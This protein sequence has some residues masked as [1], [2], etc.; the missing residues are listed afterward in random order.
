[1]SS[2]RTEDVLASTQKPVEEE[3]YHLHTLET[4]AA[5]GFL[6]IVL[7]HAAEW[8][9]WLGISHK[10]QSNSN[11]FVLRGKQID[12][13]PTVMPIPWWS[14]GEAI[15][16]VESDKPPDTS[17]LNAYES[18]GVF[19]S[20]LDFH[21]AYTKGRTTPTAVAERLL[22]SID[23][24][25]RGREPPLLAIIK[26]S[27][28]A[29]LQ[30]AADSTQRY[31][32]GKP[33]SPIDGV[34]VAVKDELDALPYETGVGTAFLKLKP[35]ADAHC[36]AKLRAAGAVIIGKTNM[37]E[38]GADVTNCNPSTGT[39]RNPYDV[40]RYTGGSS[41]G[42]GAGVA[43]GFCPLAVGADGGGSIRIPAAYNGV[44]GLKPTHGRVSGYG[45]FPLGPSVGVYGPIGATAYDLA[46]GY[47]IMAGRDEKDDLSLKQP[48]VTI[49]SFGWTKDLTGVR[50]GIYQPYFKHCDPSIARQCYKF[51]DMIVSLGATIHHIHLPNLEHYRVAH[52]NT[53]GNEMVQ[54]TSHLPRNKF[55]YPSRLMMAV[56]EQTVTA[57]DY[58]AAQ[59]VRTKGMKM[60]KKVF[61]EV[62]AVVMP[63]AGIVAPKVA[64]GAE[65]V[66]VSDYTSSGK[67]MR[68]IFLANFL[69]VPAVSFPAGYDQQSGMPVG[70]Q[71]MSSWWNED[72]LL[73]LAHASEIAL[74]K[75]RKR[76]DVFYDL[77]S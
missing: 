54:S 72:L 53:I 6:L 30:Q 12:E 28:D 49:S 35:S 21:E 52:L 73:R 76:P 24:A 29:I 45:G 36:V 60:L 26:H 40:T 51:L 9:G 67:A 50:L 65:K 15:G 46:F 25:N 20:A 31:A 14:S 32:C 74:G 19:P 64:R 38:F 42:S 18:Q 77:L 13:V 55:S 2:S 3:P 75:D 5:S 62:D 7:T 48:A 57:V 69:G 11:A 1:M 17:V 68:F 43:A 66:G 61:D 34:P 4:P 44:F 33:L 63:T 58:I 22:Q 71:F 41:G 37:H 47:A 16:R 23:E 59:R 56:L 10:I 39:P 27:R 8:I 70:L